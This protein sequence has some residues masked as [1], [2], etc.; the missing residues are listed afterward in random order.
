[1]CTGLLSVL[2]SLSVRF[3]YLNRLVISRLLVASL[4]PVAQLLYPWEEGLLYGYLIGLFLSLLMLMYIFKGEIK[5]FYKVALFDKSVVFKHI[6]FIKFTLP[7]SFLNNF[8]R[9]G[10]IFFISTFFGSMYAGFFQLSSKLVAAP[11]SLISTVYGDYLR[12]EISRD[13]SKFIYIK[14]VI[15]ITLIMLVLASIFS[16]TILNIAVDNWLVLFLGDDWFGTQDTLSVLLV[17]MAFQIV[18]NPMSSILLLYNFQK[19][20]F[21]LQ[22]L[23]LLLLLVPF[24]LDLNYIDYIR[25]YAFVMIAIY[26][27]FISVA[28]FIIYIKNKREVV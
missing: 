6:D 28:L 4:V 25:Y 9:Y 17:V 27:C 22:I 7:S 10:P 11:V 16:Y 15:R 19:V 14:K 24:A 26:L 3:S 8:V 5:R 18:G 2:N 21:L 20:D 13:L 12:S 23:M 1:M